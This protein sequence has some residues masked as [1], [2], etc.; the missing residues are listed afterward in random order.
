MQHLEPQA[1]L[2]PDRRRGG[3]KAWA[4]LVYLAREWGGLSTTELGRR[5]QRDPSLISRL[6]GAYAARREGQG[7]ARLAKELWQ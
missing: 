5:L 4:L 7:E 2:R 1:L 3:G 6:Y